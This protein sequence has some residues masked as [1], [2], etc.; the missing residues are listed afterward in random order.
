MKGN[1]KTS[2]SGVVTCQH[3]DL[4]CQGNMWSDCAINHYPAFADYFPFIQ[5]FETNNGVISSAQSCATKAKMDFS[6]LKACATGTEGHD[7][8]VNFGKDTVAHQYVPW[9][10]INGVLSTDSDFIAAVCAASAST[11][12]P[13][14]CNS[15]SLSAPI[16]PCM[17]A[18]KVKLFLF[19]LKFLSQNVNFAGCCWPLL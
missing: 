15:V 16:T 11:T 18:D 4:E 1:A 8:L 5:C 13:A 17:N 6:I 14:A 19:S 7:L 9:V 12:K 2:A 10:T 3:G